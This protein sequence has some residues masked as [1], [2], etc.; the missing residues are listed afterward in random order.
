VFV[1]EL[2]FSPEATA[3][4]L[5]AMVKGPGGQKRIPMILDTGASITIIPMWLL[6]S[7]GI[8]LE[9]PIKWTRIYSASGI[10]RIPIYKLD[11]MR[12]MDI[13]CIDML[14]GCHT[15]PSDLRTEG[16]LGLNFFT[17]KTLLLDFNKGRIE[18]N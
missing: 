4:A 1:L 11:Q 12:I 3:I 13:E 9:K 8:D 17:N 5:D 6:R 10:I 15:L 18:I 2:S 7:V 16:L 14:V